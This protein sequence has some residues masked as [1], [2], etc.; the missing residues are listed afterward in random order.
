MLGRLGQQSVKQKEQFALPGVCS[1]LP[2][3]SFAALFISLT[4]VPFASFSAFSF[5][6]ILERSY[7][8]VF[9]VHVSKEKT[10]RKVGFLE[11]HS[12]L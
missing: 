4:W 5:F 6:F 2:F 11:L 1:C 12:G 9:L 10:I 7:E 8:I 3:L